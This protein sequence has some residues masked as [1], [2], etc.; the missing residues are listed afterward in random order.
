[1]KANHGPSV[2]GMSNNRNTQLERPHSPGRGQK[3]TPKS[4]GKK[5]GGKGGF[6]GVLD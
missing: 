2:C 5:S 4:G 3:L 6:W 1:M